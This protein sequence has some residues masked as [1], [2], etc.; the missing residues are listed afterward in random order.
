MSDDLTRGL[1]ATIK[2]PE[3]ARYKSD[4]PWIVFHGTVDQISEDIVAAFGLE[5]ED[6]PTLFDLVVQAQSIATAGKV[7]A[8]ALGAKTVGA[9]AD[10]PPS[11][12]VWDQ[13]AQPAAEPQPELT[14][15]EK[16]LALIGEQPN[17][18][19]LRTLYA[20]NE[21]AIKGDPTLLEAW[22]TKGRELSKVAAA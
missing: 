18:A 20:R 11:G 9:T 13:A 1:T 4:N 2:F 19:E 8:A 12:S 7:A 6:T 5:G 3:S 22:K 21:A 17:V 14:E 16:L 10:N 15:A